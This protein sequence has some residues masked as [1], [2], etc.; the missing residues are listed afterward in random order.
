MKNMKRTKVPTALV[1]EKLQKVL[2]RAGLGSR[3]E[4]ETWIQNGRIQ[5]N[6][7]LATIGQR[8]TTR[9]EITLDGRKVHLKFEPSRQIVC[10]HKP[11]GQVCTRHDPEGRETIFER[12]P[13]LRQGRWIT[14]G[15]LDL[16]TC[17][18]LL[19]TTDGEL[20]HR[21][22]HPSYQIEREYAV[23]ILGEVTSD[24]LTRLRTG[25][26][27]AGHQFHFQQIR[28]AGGG[29]GSANHW[30]HVILTEGRH[31]EV[32][33]LW[34]SQGV[35]VSRLIRVRFGPVWLPRHLGPGHYAALDQVT[36]QALLRQVG[37]NNI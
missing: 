1:T 31:H 9:D 13:V 10:Y 16:N 21:L 15:R 3:R 4:I 30:Y 23:R 26:P 22:M 11:V 5:I 14:V 36:E 27:I 17:G 8:V 34:E 33:Q 20:A 12:L 7:Q 28:E 32:R 35:T 2:A 29:E 37:L 6:R 19:L 18:L 24:M 25:V